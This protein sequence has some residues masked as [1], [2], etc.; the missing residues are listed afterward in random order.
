MNVETFKM[1]NTAKTNDAREYN[2][3]LEMCRMVYGFG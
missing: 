1:E 2:N 3:V